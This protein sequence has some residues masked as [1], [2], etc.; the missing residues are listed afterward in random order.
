MEAAA[1]IQDERHAIEK[2]A[3]VLRGE[4]RAQLLND[5]ANAE[6]A[7]ALPDRS[8]VEFRL[9]NAEPASAGQSP[10]PVE[11][12]VTDLDGE[13]LE[14]VVYR[15]N[16]RLSELELIRYHETPVLGPQW[17]TFEIV[18]YQ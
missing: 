17:R 11:G 1:L 6:V 5:L 15:R 16:G 14:V 9:P 4:L 2:I 12:R 7:F 13:Q 8:L 18:D 10:Y 3:A